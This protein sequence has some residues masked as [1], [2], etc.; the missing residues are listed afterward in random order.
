M[1]YDKQMHCCAGKEPDWTLFLAK[2]DILWPCLYDN[3]SCRSL[4]ACTAVTTAEAMLARLQSHIMQG[5]WD[6]LGVTQHQVWH[7]AHTE[8]WC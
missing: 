2:A 6:V 8:H 5:A 1:S 3:T 4:E 7:S